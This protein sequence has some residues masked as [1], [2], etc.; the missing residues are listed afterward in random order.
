MKWWHFAYK[1][2][3]LTATSFFLTEKKKHFLDTIYGQCWGITIFYGRMVLNQDVITLSVGC[4]PQKKK[5]WCSLNTRVE[6][7]HFRVE[8][9]FAARLVCESTPT[10][11]NSFWF[12]PW[13]PSDCD[14]TLRVLEETGQRRMIWMRCDGIPL[15]GVGF[16]FC[17]SFKTKKKKCNNRERKGWNMSRLLAQR[18]LK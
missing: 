1:R 11:A 4:P 16:F 3:L 9:F 15:W 10:T 18:H 6:I 13:A 5:K 7:Q 2:S 14:C 17:L 8:S 12:L